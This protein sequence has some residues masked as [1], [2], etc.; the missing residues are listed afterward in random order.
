MSLI[1]DL[2]EILGIE[3]ESDRRGSTVP[4]G[5]WPFRRRVAVI[6][7]TTNRRPPPDSSKGS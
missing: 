3:R 5:V 4:V 2:L 1:E 7:P 6:R